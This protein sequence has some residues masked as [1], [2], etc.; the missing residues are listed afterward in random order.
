MNE[1]E[2]KRRYAIKSILQADGLELPRYRKRFGSDPFDDVPEL[3][4]LV[5]Q[6]LARRSESRLC[7]TPLGL[8]RSDAI[9]PWLYSDRVRG[10]MEAFELR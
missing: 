8:E 2:R 6:G 3:E 1:S 5:H 9:G 7:P 10:R 4:A